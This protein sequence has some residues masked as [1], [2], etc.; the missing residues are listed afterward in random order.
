[1]DLQ[2]RVEDELFI[3]KPLREDPIDQNLANFINSKPLHQR[4]KMHFERESPGIYRYH[5]KRVFMK[6]EGDTI[7]IR[8][9][10]GYMLIDDFVD[11]YCGGEVEQ[12]N[13]ITSLVYG[14]ACAGNKDFKTFYFTQ[15]NV[16]E[17]GSQA[18][19][20]PIKKTQVRGNSAK[21]MKLQIEEEAP[22]KN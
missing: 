10:G 14:G 2:H 18:G 1:M 4:T 12:T 22:Q 21:P 11:H 16:D 6:I 5:R 13:K 3:Y 7:V 8:V 20:T 17:E 19:L 9:G 15:H